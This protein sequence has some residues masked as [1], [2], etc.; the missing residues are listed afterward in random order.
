MQDRPQRCERR[1]F[2]GEPE[3]VIYVIKPFVRLLHRAVEHGKLLIMI[4]LQCCFISAARK[5]GVVDPH[6]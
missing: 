5:T 4:L 2:V 6:Q 1:P 3:P